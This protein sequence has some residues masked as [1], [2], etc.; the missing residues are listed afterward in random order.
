MK[1]STLEIR[2]AIVDEAITIAEHSSWEAVHLFD[3]ATELNI[4]LDDIR[5]HFSE[6]KNL[7]GA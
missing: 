6:K 2:E 7:V 5:A 1:K 4:S 3:V